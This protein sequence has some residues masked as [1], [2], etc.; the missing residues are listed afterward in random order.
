MT[1]QR[2]HLIVLLSVAAL[3]AAGCAKPEEPK[4]TTL[5]V[6]EHAETD[7]LHD[8]GP[9]DE[10]DSVGDSLTFFNP[11]YDESNT[12]KVGT[13]SGVC[14]RTAVG[15]AYECMWTSTVPG[16]QL[17]VEGTFYD[18]K[19]STFAIT[20]GTG[21]FAQARGEMA[22]HARNPEGTEYDFIYTIER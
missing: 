6:I 15:S 21:D 17:N 12:N 14:F 5:H 8:V 3:A 19:D 7:A 22:L 4:P 10:K 16:G 13:S 2:A 1:F 20:G 18:G 11:L 9:P